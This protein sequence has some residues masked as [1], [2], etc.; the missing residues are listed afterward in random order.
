[1]KIH[2]NYLTDEQLS[3]LR[4]QFDQ[5]ANTRQLTFKYWVTHKET[6]KEVFNSDADQLVQQERKDISKAPL[7][8]YVRDLL[9]SIF[10]IPQT[11]PIFVVR[12]HNPIGLHTD[13]DDHT[14][15][16][17]RTLIIPLTFDDRIVTVIWDKIVSERELNELIKQFAEHPE[18]FE[19]QNNISEQYKLNNCWFGDPVLTDYLPLGKVAIWRTGTVIEFNRKNIHASN[20]YTNFL[21]Y[22]DYILIH[23]EE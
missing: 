8:Q 15:V 7:G 6:I 13:C 17:G 1:M 4:T 22:K 9:K 2:E 14:P 23:T 18:I 12:S 5:Y 10:D 11:T 19:K 3:S 21:P 16:N 20:N